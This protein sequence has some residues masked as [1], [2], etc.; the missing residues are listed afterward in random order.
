MSLLGNIIWFLFG[1]FLIGLGY[2]IWGLVFCFTIIG[3]PF[4]YQLIKLGLFSMLPFGQRPQFRNAE[5][6]CISFVFNI[7]WIL[8]GGLW[9]AIAHLVLGLI[10]CATII[11]IPFGLQHFK[12]AQLACF[13]FGQDV[14]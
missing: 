12:L 1:G 4:G 9:I 5:M 8:C 6:G 11:G 7:I 10:F 2:I 13:P 3:I 14:V